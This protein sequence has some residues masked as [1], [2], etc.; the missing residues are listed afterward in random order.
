MRLILLGAP[1]S[2]KG[3]QGGLLSNYYMIP[4]ISTGDILRENLK[5]E[6][7]LGKQAKQ[8]MDK[9]ELVPDDV[10]ISIV[11]QRLL[12]ADC[13]NG[14]I[15]DG[16]PRTVPQAQALD[17]YLK[18]QNRE[19]QHVVSLEVEEEPIV[20][21]ITSRRLCRNCGKDYNMVTN[22]P[23]ADMK[24]TVCGGEIWQ[25]PD[26][27]EETVRNRLKVYAEKTQPLKDHYAQQGVLKS[28]AGEGTIDTI[29]QRIREYLSSDDS[30]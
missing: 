6:T 5:N 22:P 20:A 9:G 19:I 13:D 30:N 17:A 2:G 25:R 28:F 27:T 1:G 24:C 23:P 10:I 12:E 29:Q 15:L 4:N 26:D 21:R 14:F 18:S 16:F 11:K 7:E 3:T 8:F